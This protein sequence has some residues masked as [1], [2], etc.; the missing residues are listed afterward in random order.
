MPGV[1][2]DLDAIR[3]GT[4][5][6]VS[7]AAVSCTG[8]VIR[9]EFFPLNSG[10]AMAGFCPWRWRQAAGHVAECLNM[11]RGSAWLTRALAD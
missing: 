8:G 1:Q 6:A 2:V 9:H 4:D 7:S 10:T 11:A 3:S 5:S